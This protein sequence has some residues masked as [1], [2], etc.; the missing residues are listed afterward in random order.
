VKLTLGRIADWIHADGEFD[1]TAEALGY[2]IDSRTI[3]AGELFFAVT[4]ERLDG[5]DYVAAALENGAVAAVVSNLLVVPWGVDE[6]KLLKVA[7]GEDCVL[8]AMQALAQAV[9]RDWGGRVIGVTGSAGK[10][11]TKEMVAQVLSAKFKVLKSAGNL[12]NGFGV[13]LQLLRL[14]PE[15]EVAVIEMGMNHAGEIAALAKIAEPN[16]GVVSN[17]APVHVE[18]FEDGIAGVARAKY[19]LIEALPED[20]VAVLNGDDRYVREFGRGMGERAVFYGTDEG[21]SVIAVHIAEMGVEGVVFTVEA[22]GERASVQLQL[23]GRHNVLNALAAIAV[24]LRS[25][26]SLGECAAAVGEMRAGDKRGEVIVWRGATLIN[27]CYNS[28]PR[29]LEAMVD[30]L[31]AMP[32]ERH[33]VIAGEMLELGAA[34]A[35]LHAACG[36][37]MAERGVSLVIGVRG[38]A[39][40]LVKAAKTGGVDA[41]F[42]P[43]ALAAG[44]WIQQNVQ[45]GDAVLLKASRGV[46]LERALAGLE[47]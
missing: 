40:A 6:A 14:E 21:V 3:G 18:F 28:N 7:S 10:T 34:A 31:M 43:D 32:A 33:I 24:G 46:R 17:V 27:D 20:G 23:L 26:L 13:P 9:R 39:E 22:A 37:R 8:R 19:E 29:A 2:S 42:V 41:V 11:T 38:A 47:I 30:A 4:G 36:R 45:A 15:H 12:N 35:E 1:T 5:H 44:Q 16:W 25:G